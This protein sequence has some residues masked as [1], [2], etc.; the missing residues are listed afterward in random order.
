M[1]FCFQLGGAMKQGSDATLVMKKTLCVSTTL[2]EKT[3]FCNVLRYDAKQECIY[4]VLENDLLPA[5]SL[6]AIYECT[7]GETENQVLC[8]G[9]IKER[10][11]NKFGKI[12]KFEIENG[13]YKISLKSV[14]K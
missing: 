14:D 12:L 8:T 11:Q 3:Y 5:I 13:F 7:M 1:P 4:L 10:Y 2:D 6:D 9:R